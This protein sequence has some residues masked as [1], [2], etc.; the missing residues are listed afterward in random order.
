MVIHKAATAIVI[1]VCLGL[2][3]GCQP[4]FQEIFVSS[5]ETDQQLVN[6]AL[7]ENG[8]V[9]SVSEDNADYPASALT[10]GVTSTENWDKGAG[11]QTHFE[12]PYVY[13]QYAGPGDNQWFAQ[14]GFGGPNQI[15]ITGD[16][17]IYVRQRP[18]LRTFEDR[19][20]K[21]RG[22]SVMGYDGPVASAMGWVVIELPTEQLITRV[23]VHTVD[24][25]Q[26]PAAKYGVRDFVVQYWPTQSGGWHNVERLSKKVGRQHDSIRQNK[27]GRVV[28]RFRPV[29]TSKFRLIV[30]WTNDTEMYRK[31]SFSRYVRGTVRLT[32]IEI[33]GLEKKDE[34][35]STPPIQSDEGG[36]ETESPAA[37]APEQGP[38]PPPEPMQEPPIDTKYA[39]GSPEAEI[40]AVIR[41]Y[42]TAYRNRDL[43][44][45]MATISPAYLRGAEDYAQFKEKMQ[46]L[47]EVYT[48]L[49]LQLQR[50]RINADAETATVASDYTVALA[51]AI[52]STT[53]VSGKLFFTLNY[54]DAGWQVTRIDTQRY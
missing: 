23:I 18:R 15:A 25:E 14:R 11:W 17:Q 39:A 27:Q 7:P 34:I 12:G 6:Y 30:R 5:A 32:E 31:T 24:T 22:V 52:S 4:A 45:V 29:K 50:V 51:S 44:A 38:A 20:Y 53:S 19:D 46:S 28:V 21:T 1:S 47:F 10:D 48:Q 42:E 37:V 40:E 36:S 26:Y 16:G 13:G 54:S 3:L 49:D 8:A 2:I 35:A 43:S 9:V 33:F 41:A